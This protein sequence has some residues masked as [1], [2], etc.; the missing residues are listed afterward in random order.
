M[1]CSELFG[2]TG[3]FSVASTELF[4]GVRVPVIPLESLFSS[5]GRLLGERGL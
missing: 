4:V 3:D 1:I 5:L 2:S